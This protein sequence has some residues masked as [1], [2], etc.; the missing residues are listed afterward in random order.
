MI[1]TDKPMEGSPKTL[2]TVTGPEG[3][4]SP[5][6]GSV[7]SLYRLDSV[8]ATPSPDGSDGSWFRY[9]IVQGTNTIT[10]FRAGSLAE[11]NPILQDMVTRLNERAG[12]QLAKS[13]K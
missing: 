5:A 10:G 8:V 4:A 12:K 3:P 2:A 11:L 6:S 9:V 13:K 1:N 7:E